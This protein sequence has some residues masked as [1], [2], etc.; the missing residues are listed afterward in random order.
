[1]VCSPRQSS[2]HAALYGALWLPRAG[3]MLPGIGSLPLSTL[4]GTFRHQSICWMRWT[5]SSIRQVGFLR[6]G[7]P[8][9]LA[10]QVL[11]HGRGS[12]THV[13]SK[14][15]LPWRPIS[16]PPALHYAPAASLESKLFE[17]WVGV[18]HLFCILCSLISFAR[19]EA[20]FCCVFTEIKLITMVWPWNYLTEKGQSLP[21]KNTTN[22]TFNIY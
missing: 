11:E 22:I 6:T 2:H 21:P 5:S 20:H 7:I 8:S 15:P 13:F 4:P 14:G 19:Y 10:P 17:G 9:T 3:W 12:L 1:M 16:W 18:I